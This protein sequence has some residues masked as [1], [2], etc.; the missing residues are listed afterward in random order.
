MKYP[1]AR[2]WA[3]ELPATTPAI[4]ITSSTFTP[5]RLSRVIG[6]H[7]KTVGAEWLNVST[8]GHIA[9]AIGRRFIRDAAITSRGLY[10]DLDRD[11]DE[12]ASDQEEDGEKDTIINLQTGHSVW[13]S[14][15]V[16]GRQ[17][18]EGNW[19]TMQRRESFRILSDEW[20]R[21]L[22]LSSAGTLQT[23]AAG[24]GRLPASTLSTSSS[25]AGLTY[26]SSSSNS[27]V[28]MRDSHPARSRSSTP[29]SIIRAL[30]SPSSPPGA[31]RASSS[32]SQQPAASITSGV[33]VVIVP[34]VS[35][36]GNLL[37]RCADL[38]IPAVRWAADHLPEKVS[39]VFATPEA[40]MTKRF[41]SYLDG[42]Q[43]LARLD[44]IVIG[45][46]HSNLEGTLK[47]RPK[48]RELAPLPCGASR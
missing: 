45:E 29:S 9:T 44:R 16:Y 31:A 38:K 11:D 1:R 21:L 37:D 15:L 19:E 2:Q 47:F 41:Q 39:L 48:M 8:W 34:L 10:G 3:D 28:P 30:P 26:C 12:E 14:G 25:S 32:S 24:P 7:G 5:A 6:R 22:G 33:T 36:L 20:H 27:S 35:L 17:V 23:V 43:S 42:L 40:A 13:T 4:G 18:G 46:C